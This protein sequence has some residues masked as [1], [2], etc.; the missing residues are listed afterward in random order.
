MQNKNRSSNTYTQ[1]PSHINCNTQQLRRHKQTHTHTHTR[2]HACNRFIKKAMEKINREIEMRAQILKHRM[3]KVK[4]Q[5]TIVYCE[6]CRYIVKRDNWITHNSKLHMLNCRYCK[7]VFDDLKTRL[8]H[9]REFHCQTCKRLIPARRSMIKH[10]FIDHP[11]VQW[12]CPLCPNFKTQNKEH[13]LK[14]NET[15]YCR[16]CR[17]YYEKRSRMEKHMKTKHPEMYQKKANPGEKK[18]TDNVSI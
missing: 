14:H 7:N 1:Q 15:H 2:L 16:M 17:R 8:G 3:K 18:N 13:A 10:H 9:E 6:P 11:T 5:D 4:F 12:K